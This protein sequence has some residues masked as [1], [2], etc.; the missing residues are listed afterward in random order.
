MN[1]NFEF[2]SF[3]DDLLLSEEKSPFVVQVIAK[4]VGDTTQGIGNIAQASAK[5]KEAEAKIKEIGGKRQAQLKDC[6]TNKSFKKFADPKY[7]KNRIRACQEQV[8]KRIDLEENEQKEIVRRMASIEESKIASD[9]E[10]EKG[11]I[12]E[13]KSS[14]KLYVYGGIF[15][16]VL[17][18]GTII[19][20]KS[21]ITL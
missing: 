4:A 9:V 13:K 5:K 10:K 16:L 19:Y 17:V 20:L 21:R 18:L 11:S 3:N 12:D 1:T 14:K 15:A 7:R 8:N 6:E 2:D